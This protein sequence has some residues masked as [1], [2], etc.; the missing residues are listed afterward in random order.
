MD[1]FATYAWRDGGSSTSGGSLSAEKAA[2]LKW[3]KT[4][5]LVTAVDRCVQPHG[6]Y[7]HMTECPIAK[8]CQ[9]ARIKPSSAAPPK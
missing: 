3:W 6:G 4:E 9:D 5:L 2:M 7:G 8:A 1:L